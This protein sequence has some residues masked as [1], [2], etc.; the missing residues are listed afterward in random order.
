[1]GI[2]R[3]KS[4]GC[5]LS[6][7]S[8][9]KEKGKGESKEFRRF[10]KLFNDSGEKS[11]LKNVVKCFVPEKNGNVCVAKDMGNILRGPRIFIGTNSK[12]RKIGKKLHSERINPVLPYNYVLP[13]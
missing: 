6:R 12:V 11:S 9:I 7:L 4:D 1:M 3:H 5:P 10:W 13:P 2:L 8:E